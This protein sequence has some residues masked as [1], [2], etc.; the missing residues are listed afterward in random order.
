MAG[1]RERTREKRERKR[2]RRQMTSLL[3]RKYKMFAPF[4]FLL[5]RWRNNRTLSSLG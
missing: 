1:R 2:R 4:S 3:A 5:L